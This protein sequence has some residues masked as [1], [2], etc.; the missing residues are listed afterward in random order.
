MRGTLR[1]DER[2]AGTMGLE[3]RRQDVASARWTGVR[4]TSSQPLGEHLRLSTEIEVAAADERSDRGAAWPWALAALAWRPG[5]GWEAAGAVEAGSTPRNRFE[6]N[7]LL[8]VARTL[9]IP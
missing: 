6:W 4:I 9:E 3:V 5:K 7:G 1:L 2:G 8:R